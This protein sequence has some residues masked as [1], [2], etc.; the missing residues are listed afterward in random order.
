MTPHHH[1]HLRSAVKVLQTDHED[2]LL[3]SIDAHNHV[4]D[5]SGTLEDVRNTKVL[6]TP[7]SEHRFPAPSSEAGRMS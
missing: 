7:H 4:D 3:L 5:Y 1:V 2:L 6:T